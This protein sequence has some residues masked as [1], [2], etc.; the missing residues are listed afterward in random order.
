MLA[1]EGDDAST[2]LEGS[3]AREEVFVV[4]EEARKGVAFVENGVVVGATAASC[5]LDGLLRMEPLL[6]SLVRR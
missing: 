1:Q 6:R 3:S 5:E 2:L 4:D